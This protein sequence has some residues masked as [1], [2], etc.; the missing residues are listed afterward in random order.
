M[1]T[2]GFLRRNLGRAALAA[3]LC[4]VA[5]GVVTQ[6]VGA[7]V[8]SPSSDRGG[9]AVEAATP[10]GDIRPP[11]SSATWLA[12]RRSIFDSTVATPSEVVNDLIAITPSNRALKWRTFAGQRYLLVQTL[13]RDALGKPGERV[14]LTADRWVAIPSQIAARCAAARCSAMSAAALDLRLKQMLGLPPDGDF[15]FVNQLWV[16]SA[17]VFRPCTDPRVTTTTCPRLVPAGGPTPSR[18]GSTD[19]ATFLWVQANFAWRAPD[20]FAGAASFS[21][22]VRWTNPN[23]YGLP[24]TRLGYAY[25]WRPGAKEEG[26]SEFIVVRGASVV[27]DSVRTQRQVYGTG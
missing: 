3:A 12:Y 5:A 17:D 21:C 7:Q 19:V 24:W 13:R 2:V 20:T 22:A 9:A 27:I 6:P 1:R 18:V 10:R 4:G 23:C 11:I 26:P 14:S 8:G 15:R 25:D 16:R